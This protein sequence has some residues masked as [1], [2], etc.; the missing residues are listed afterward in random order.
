[1]SNQSLDLQKLNIHNHHLLDINNN[2]LYCTQYVD[3]NNNV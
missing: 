3:I 2:I 1:M